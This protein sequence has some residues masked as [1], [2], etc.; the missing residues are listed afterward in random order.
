MADLRDAL[1]DALTRGKDAPTDVRGLVNVAGGTRAVAGMLGV[2]QRTVQRWTTETAA[3]RRR[4]PASALGRLRTALRN[5]PGYRAQLLG[6]GRPGSRAA[7]LRNRGAT[8]HFR[9]RTVSGIVAGGRA[10]VRTRTVPDRQLT[11]A[12]MAP[13]VDA[14]LRGNDAAAEHLFQ[15]AYADAYDAPGWEFESVDGL[16]L[17]R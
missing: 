1:F 7:R 10:Y 3:Q 5:T 4:V 11:G 6:V 12:Q 14:F 17:K 9:G 15:E 8:A 13:V 2:T 16:D